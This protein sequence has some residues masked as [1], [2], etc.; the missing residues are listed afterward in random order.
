M[1]RKNLYCS[2]TERCCVEYDNIIEL[3][4]PVI[5]NGSMQTWHTSTC[6]WQFY[7]RK[8]QSQKELLA[9]NVQWTESWS[10]CTLMDPVQTTTAFPA[11]HTHTHTGK[12]L[13]ASVDPIHEWFLSFWWQELI[14]NNL[15]SSLFSSNPY[16]SNMIQRANGDKKTE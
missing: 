13:H 15:V 9:I 3:Y 12:S 10:Y 16:S 14:N 2:N 11:F 7:N 8:V 1:D 5:L 6:Y 4:Q